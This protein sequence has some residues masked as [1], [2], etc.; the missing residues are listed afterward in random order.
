MNRYQINITTSTG[1]STCYSGLFAHSVDAVCD[2]LDRFP[3]AKRI[4]VQALGGG[5]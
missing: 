4:S 2:A 3:H 5:Q 1:E